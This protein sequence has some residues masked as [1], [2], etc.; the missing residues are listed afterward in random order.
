LPPGRPAYLLPYSGTSVTGG[1]RVSLGGVKVG[2]AEFHQE[3]PLAHR[4]AELAVRRA[5]GTFVI[6][7]N[8][9]AVAYLDD[10]FLVFA[11]SP[12][13]PDLGT[14]LV[15]SGR[16]PAQWWDQ[17]T[18]DG[19][20]GPGVADLLSSHRFITAAELRDL[21]ESIT[22]DALLAVAVP[23]AG[24]AFRARAAFSPDRPHWAG[25]VLRLEV[26]RAWEYVQQQVRRA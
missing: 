2:T 14:R 23:L 8:P 17:V 9:G 26:S 11:E 25:S 18:A 7:G 20:P 19:D 4:L 6:N 16:V 12:G 5:Q 15:R 13:V 21:L 1:A 24:N 10:G 22:L 3:V